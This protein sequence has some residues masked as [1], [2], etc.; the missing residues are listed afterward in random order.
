LKDNVNNGGWLPSS[1]KTYYNYLKPAFDAVREKVEASIDKNI[2]CSIII[3]E[4]TDRLQRP[5]LDIILKQADHHPYLIDIIQMRRVNNVTVSQEV[6]H[7]LGK[8]NYS[9]N[10]V[11]SLV[12]DGAAYNKKAWTDSLSAMFPNAT[13]VICYCHCLNLIIDDIINDKSVA[14]AA[15]FMYSFKDYF[16]HSYL[17]TNR[18]IDFQFECGENHP[19]KPPKTSSTRWDS[20]SKLISYHVSKWKYYNKFFT[21]EYEVNNND[22]FTKSQGSCKVLNKIVPFIIENDE[23]SLEVK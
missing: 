5:A 4:S 9:F 23:K 22:S 19:S 15:D 20:W 13:F 7:S 14:I 16:Q 6:L 8:I 2:P 1:C 11:V 3:D 17:R 12:L 21:S 18:Y 10:N